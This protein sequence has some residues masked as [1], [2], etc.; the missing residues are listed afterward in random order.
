MWTNL[1]L[2]WPQVRE[3]WGAKVR[4]ALPTNLFQGSTAGERQHFA[5]AGNVPGTLYEDTE[6]GTFQRMS[7]EDSPKMNGRLSSFEINEGCFEGEAPQE[8]ISAWQAGWNVTNAIQG[9]VVVSL[10]L[11][12]LHGGV[13]SLVAMIGVAQLTCYTGKILVDCLYEE[14]ADGVLV[15]VRDSYVGIAQVVFGPR[16]GGILVNTAQIIELIMTCIL[17]IITCG[18]FLYG[19]F[20][21]AQ[22]DRR[23]WMMLCGLLLLPCGFLK[24]L[25]RV[26]TLSFWCTM[27]HIVI[28]VVILG[29]CLTRAGSWEWGQLKFGMDIT[30]FPI[31][32]GNIVFSYTS[33]IFLPTLEG[34]MRDPNEFWPMLKWSH[35]AAAVFKSL[36]GLLGFLTWGEA[37]KDEIT[38]NLPTQGFKAF[39][40]FI[41]VIKALLSFALPYFAAVELMR[42]ALFR[43]RPRTRFPSCYDPDGVVRVWGVALRIGVVVITI[44]LA[45]F[46]PHFLDL[47]G[48]IGSFTGTILSILLPC[49]FHL[50]LK[51]HL[52]PWYIKVYEWFVIALGLLFGYFGMS[53]SSVDLYRVITE[54]IPSIHI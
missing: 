47:T 3:T 8:K 33:Q 41:L 7:S 46:V 50:K 13:W 29:Y 9:M 23:S 1:R 11:A 51:G 24:S 32:L 26:S 19:S 45:A 40:N 54:S 35:I 12:V 2:L 30:K 39:V 27:A 14:N 4:E 20:P 36:F 38:N 48:L 16:W 6:M 5:R 53:T 31:S 10:P 18:D 52:L 21:E 22:V 37:V 44:L 42:S 15:R 25:G 17:Y 34:N 43:G 49:W 28:N